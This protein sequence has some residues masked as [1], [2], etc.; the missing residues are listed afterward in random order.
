[1]GLLRM[2]DSEGHCPQSCPLYNLQAEFPALPVE[3]QEA[4]QGL[5]NLLLTDFTGVDRASRRAR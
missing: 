1:M 2:H 4:V 3:M 5:L